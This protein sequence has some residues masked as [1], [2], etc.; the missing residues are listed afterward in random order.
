MGLVVLDY[1][2][3]VTHESRSRNDPQHVRV[4][5]TSRRLKLLART[6]GVG[7]PLAR[8]TRDLWH[9]AVRALPAGADHTEIYRYL[10]ALK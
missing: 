9:S 10:E 7:T 1:L 5:D 6:L 3:L 4:G 2:Q 8:R